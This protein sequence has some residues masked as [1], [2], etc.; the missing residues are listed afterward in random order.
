MPPPSCLA[1]PS[2]APFTTGGNDIRALMVVCRYLGDVL[3]ATPLAQS[4]KHAGYAVDWVVAPGT[5][6]LLEQQPYANNVV[7]IGQGISWG[8]QLGLGAKLFRKY[9]IAFVL[10]ASDRSM[11]MALAA[12]GTVYALIDA[13]RPQDA[14]KR[15]LAHQWLPYE[16]HCHMVHYAIRLSQSA[17]I[18]PCHDIHIHWSEANING[19]HAALPWK[20]STPFIHLHP[21]ARWPYKWW[22][23][24]GWCDLVKFILDEGFKVA[25]TASPQ[26]NEAAHK[27]VEE[28]AADGVCVLAGEL[29][30]QQLA[31]LS[32]CASAY[33]G[34]DTANTH[35]AASTGTPVIALF[36]PTDPRIWGPWP[37]GFDGKT[38]WQARSEN[39]IQ[40]YGN[41]SLLQGTQDCVPCQL[42][43]CERRPDSDSACLQDMQAEWVWQEVQHQLA[44]AA[45]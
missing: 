24:K 3:L 25:I 44:E 42:E 17:N 21:F 2:S 34:L 45:S 19:V 36:G 9:D 37:N 26:E 30:W 13:N 32:H 11:A 29:N 16:K 1:S 12:S 5:G 43:G 10:P 35:L 4:L 8:R 15:K 7:T 18:K 31:C 41:I 40:R 20:S 14:W 33:I 22:N 39:G 27:L 38:P 23:R 6:A 28:Y